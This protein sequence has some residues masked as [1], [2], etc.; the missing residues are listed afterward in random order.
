[1]RNGTLTQANEVPREAVIFNAHAVDKDGQD[2]M[3]PWEITRFVDV[4]TIPPKGYKYGKY[5]FNLPDEATQITVTAK[6]HYRSFSQ[7]F[8]DLLLG[9]DAV[10]V[11]SVEMV[12]I[13]ETF[14]TAALKL[15]AAADDKH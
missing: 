15:A 7:G 4:N 13:E 2:T 1:M 10:K 8:A 6:L 9:K 14:D 5:Y 3:L 12:S 11:P